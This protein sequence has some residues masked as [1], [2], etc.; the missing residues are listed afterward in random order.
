MNSEVDLKRASLYETDYQL[1]L[2]KTVAQMKTDCPDY[3]NHC[4]Y[5]SR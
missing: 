4:F 3:L 1:W 2:D 5:L